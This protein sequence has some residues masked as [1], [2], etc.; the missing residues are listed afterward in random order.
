MFSNS[1]GL[2]SFV[3]NPGLVWTV[4]RDGLLTV[5]LTVEIK[6]RLQMDMFTR[7]N[8]QVSFNSWRSRARNIFQSPNNGCRFSLSIT[9]S[10]YFIFSLV[11][12][13]ELDMDRIGCFKDNRKDPRPLP[14]YIMTDRQRGLK[15]SSGQSIDWRNWDVYLPEFICRC[16]KKAKERGHNT[17][18]MQFYGEC[19]DQS[20]WLIY[21]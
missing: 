12:D 9:P 1:S 20:L 7:P 17:F 16:A 3:I 10:V 13:C 5:G 4:V 6:L 11:T 8:Y 2:Q 18:G 15:V 19:R 14:E 21:K